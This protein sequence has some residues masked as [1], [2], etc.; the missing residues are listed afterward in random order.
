MNDVTALLLKDVSFTDQTHFHL[1]DFIFPMFTP[2]ILIF[3]FI[4]FLL[5]MPDILFFRYRNSLKNK[6]N[7]LNLTFSKEGFAVLY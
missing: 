3:F 2:Q 4:P 1:F 5:I 6:T 7:R